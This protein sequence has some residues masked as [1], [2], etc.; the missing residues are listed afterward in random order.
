MW[1]RVNNINELQEG[2]IIEL[3]TEYPLLLHYA[4]VVIENDEKKCAHYPY[5]QTPRIENLDYV[6]NNRPDNTIRRILRTGIKSEQIIQNHNQIK[7]RVENN[8]N[9]WLLKYNCENYIREVTGKSIGIDQRINAI[10]VIV[11][12]ILI[13]IAI[14]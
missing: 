9:T 10:L 11:I 6:I 7:D 4:V 8:F 1:L 5:P 14:K 12:I 13:I 2:D 3:N